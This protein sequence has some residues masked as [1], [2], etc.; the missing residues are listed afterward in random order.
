MSRMTFGQ[1]KDRFETAKA[2]LKS[3]N[4]AGGAA[5]RAKKDEARQEAIERR[6]QADQKY[7][8]VRL[9]GMPA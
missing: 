3:R 1:F 2:V 8:E 6:N 4:I 5:K 9:P 7:Q